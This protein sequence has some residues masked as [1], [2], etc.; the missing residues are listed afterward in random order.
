MTRRSVRL[1][2]VA[3]RFIKRYQHFRGIGSV[4]DDE[5]AALV[6]QIRVVHAPRALHIRRSMAVTDRQWRCN[7]QCPNAADSRI[8]PGQRLCRTILPNF[9]K[10]R[11]TPSERPVHSMF[12]APL[13]LTFP[14]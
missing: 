13:T 14:E 8:A 7:L 10:V 5:V 12:L 3:K 4:P 6:L 9:W 1:T 11:V 2:C